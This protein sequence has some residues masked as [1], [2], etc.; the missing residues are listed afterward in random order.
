MNIKKTIKNTEKEI[1]QN[2]MKTEESIPL[3]KKTKTKIQ[4]KQIFE[5]INYSY[6]KNILKESRRKRYNLEDIYKFEG[7]GNLNFDVNCF[8]EFFF[9][10]NEISSISNQYS[11]I[12]NELSKNLK[13]LI[14]SNKNESGNCNVRYNDNLSL[15]LKNRNFLL[16]MKTSQKKMPL[17]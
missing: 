2:Y 6:S 17:K 7:L 12:S 4:E 11:Q 9:L 13:E 5:T 1:N 10:F 16:K 3:N 14:N 8:Y 15:K